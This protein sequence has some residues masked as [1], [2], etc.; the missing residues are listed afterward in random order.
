MLH[1]LAALARQR[2]MMS[3]DLV[4]PQPLAQLVRNALGQLSRVDEDQGGS[5]AG[6]V[7]ADAVED[8]AELIAGEGRLELAVGQLER[9]IHAAPVPAVDDGGGRLTRAHQQAGRRLNRPNRRREPDADGRTLG[10]GLEPLEREGEM[11]APLVS[12]QGVDLVDDDRLHAGEGGPGPFGGQV[13]I[14]GFR[15]GDQEVRGPPGHHLP[16]IRGGITG[17]HGDG[18]GCW[19]VAELP[20]ELG[21]LGE[22][23]FEVGV[24]VD[25]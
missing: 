14:Q 22:G 12:G 25:G 4:L 13:Q 21:D 7:A 23:L 15:R 17:P 19:F 18:D 8:L 3:G 1:S 24:D 16:L 9:Q 5:V 20:S 2:S 10:H 6:N 11:R